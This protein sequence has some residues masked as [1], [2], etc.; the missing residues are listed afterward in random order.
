M[1]GKWRHTATAST[2]AGAAETYMKPGATE[3]GVAWRFAAAAEKRAPGRVPVL[4]AS[5]RNHLRENTR[6][7]MISRDELEAGQISGERDLGV[8]FADLVGFTRLGGELEPGELDG[9]VAR[10]GELAT[11]VAGAKVRLVKT[12]GDAAMYASSEPPRL[13]SATLELLELAE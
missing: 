1:R 10:F 6:L 8:C 3:S 12:I 13:V 2:A 4:A 5:F 11:E 9:V 7:G